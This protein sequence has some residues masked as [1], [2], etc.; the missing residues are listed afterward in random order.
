MKFNLSSEN[1]YCIEINYKIV[2]LIIAKVCNLSFLLLNWVFQSGEW[3]APDEVS[4]SC[5]PVSIKQW[6]H[7][8]P[9]LPVRVG[10]APLSQSGFF[11]RERETSW[12]RMQPYSASPRSTPAAQAYTQGFAYLEKALSPGFRRAYLCRLKSRV[13]LH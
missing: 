9:A 11:T 2:I 12:T 6:R 13:V 8:S 3:E 4:A 5:L 7:I 1:N 10:G